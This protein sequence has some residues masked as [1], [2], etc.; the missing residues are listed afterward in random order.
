MT[1]GRKS[2][3]QGAWRRTSP[4]ILISNPRHHTLTLLLSFSFSSLFLS[5]LQN[6]LSTPS[7]PS[8]SFHPPSSILHSPSDYLAACSG[9]AKSV[10][11]KISDRCGLRFLDPDPNFSRT[12]SKFNL[13]SLRRRLPITL[14]HTVSYDTPQR[15]LAASSAARFP[16]YLAHSLW[17]PGLAIHNGK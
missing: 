7:T 16:K 4:K 6:T 12:I 8:I 2:G 17:V 3:R 10:I 14:S 9:K 13:V 11:S 1:Q 15:N 5:P